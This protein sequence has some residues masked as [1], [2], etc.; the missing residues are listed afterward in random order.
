VF[1]P[2][3]P[4]R[5]GGKKTREISRGIAAV[6]R[7]LFTKLTGGGIAYAIQRKKLRG[8]K[9][10][11]LL[12]MPK[13]AGGPEDASKVGQKGSARQLTAARTRNWP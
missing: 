13:K 5:T 6:Q 2:T 9:V 7:K 11:S 12:I 4:T 3:T 10:L 1:P 8:K